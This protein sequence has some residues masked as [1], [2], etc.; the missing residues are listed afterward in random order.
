MPTQDRI[1]DFVKSG[2]H[3]L[4]NAEE[5]M[6]LPTRAAQ[7]S[8]A[9]QRHLRA[10]MY[11]AGYAVECMLKAYLSEQEECQALGAT[12]DKIKFTGTSWLRSKTLGECGPV[13]IWMALFA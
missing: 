9:G 10:A 7:G 4:Q 6:E 3:R 13:A 5:L 2:P 11:L 8:D 1:S 12:Q